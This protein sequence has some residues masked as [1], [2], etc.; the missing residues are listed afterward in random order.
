MT[1]DTVTWTIMVDIMEDEVP[2]DLAFN[3]HPG[4]G[5]YQINRLAISMLS[6]YTSEASFLDLVRVSLSVPIPDL[7]SNTFIP[8]KAFTKK[9]IY[10]EFGILNSTDGQSERICD[11]YCSETTPILSCSPELCFTIGGELTSNCNN[12]LFSTV[13]PFTDLTY[14]CNGVISSS[15]KSSSLQKNPYKPAMIAITV[16]S[17]ILIIVLII[18]LVIH[19]KHRKKS[20]YLR[21]D[22]VV[23]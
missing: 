1:L 4:P 11:L 22:D 10:G 21:I 12:D 5:L 2:D 6:C 3:L 19:Y 13:P 20:D 23:E 16:I 15:S 17:G 7:E 8:L 14:D 18:S 9:P